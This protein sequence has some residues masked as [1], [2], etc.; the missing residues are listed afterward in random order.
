MGRSQ[1]KRL[2]DFMR[3]QEIKRLQ[4]LELQK[5]IAIDYLKTHNTLAYDNEIYPVT[6]KVLTGT[7]EALKKLLTNELTDVSQLAIDPLDFPEGLV[8]ERGEGFFDV[9]VP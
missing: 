2:D 7:S 1:K 4:E 5:Q 3:G 6:E 8:L 9:Y